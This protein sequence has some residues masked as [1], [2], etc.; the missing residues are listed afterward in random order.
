MSGSVYKEIAGLWGIVEDYASG[1]YYRPDIYKSKS[2]QVDL[3]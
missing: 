2:D 1:V 3:N